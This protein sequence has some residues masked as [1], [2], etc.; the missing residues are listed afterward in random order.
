MNDPICDICRSEHEFLIHVLW[1]CIFARQVWTGLLSSSLHQDFFN[2]DFKTWLCKNLL[3]EMGNQRYSN[4]DVIFGVV[5]TP[6]FGS[7]ASIWW[8][9]RFLFEKWFIHYFLENDLMSSLI[10]ILFLKSK[11]NKKENSK[12]D[13]L[14]WKMWFVKNRI[15]IGEHVT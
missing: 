14:L 6:Y 9:A 7:C 13:S 4:W 5:W 2:S 1:D 10:F 11:Q 3:K 12:C 8:R 15:K